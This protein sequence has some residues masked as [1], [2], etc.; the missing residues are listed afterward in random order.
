MLKTRNI[1]IDTQ[2]FVANNFFANENLLR[3][4]KFGEHGTINIYLTEITIQEIQSNIREE[5]LNAQQEINRFL[6]DISNKG[7]ILKNIEKFQPYFDLPRLDLEVDFSTLN[8]ELQKFITDGKVKIIPYNL[9]NLSEIMT[10]YFNKEKPFGLEKK[11]HEFPDAIVLSALDRWCENNKC[12]IYAISEDEDL[13]K[14][15]SANV[16]IIPKLRTILDKI[17]RQYKSDRIA[18]IEEVYS[19]SE[20]IIIQKIEDR[21]TDEMKFNSWFGVDLTFLEVSE[22][23]LYEPS[24]VQDNEDTG[25][26]IFQLEADIYFSVN[27][28]F[29]DVS[30]NH[31]SSWPQKERRKARRTIGT[32]QTVEIAIEINFD[33]RDLLKPEASSIFCSYCSVP[34][35][36]SIYGD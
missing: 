3:L 15:V 6:K 16:I 19:N 4:S 21:F 35:S 14:Y 2:T 22:I 5:L 28:I 20:E 26:T 13:K 25:E 18:W 11:K 29:E 30:R 9:A 32:T 8:E 17:N 36:D 12:K 10:R 27:G 34:N 33:E 23:I 7:R 1:Y 31:D 24:I